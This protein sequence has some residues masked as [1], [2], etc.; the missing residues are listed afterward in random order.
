VTSG[1]PILEL[2]QPGDIPDVMA[3]E[4]AAYAKGWPAT[5]FEREL[6]QNGMARYVVLR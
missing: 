2:M 3:V 4:R 1:P 6:T 5:A